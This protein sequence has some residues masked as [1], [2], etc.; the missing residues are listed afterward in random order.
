MKIIK[1]NSFYHNHLH[2]FLD[3]FYKDNLIHIFTPYYE[4]LL[5]YNITL[6]Y[7][8]EILKLKNEYTL[9]IYE[10]AK[11]KLY[12]ISSEESE[13]D[14]LVESEYGNKIFHLEHIK[15]VKDKL[16]ITSTMF[17]DDYN[18]FN[19]YYDYYMKHG[20]DYFYM[21]YN[22]IITPEIMKIF[23]KPNVQLIEWDFRYYIKSQHN[24]AIH[25]AQPSQINHAL[26]RFGKGFTQY[27]IFNDFDEYMSIPKNIENNHGIKSYKQYNLRDFV[28]DNPFDSYYFCNIW[29]NTLDNKIP[30]KFPYTFKIGAK[31]D[32]IGT[33][34]KCIHNV[35]TF[36]Y[37]NIHECCDKIETSKRIGRF[38]LFHFYNWSNKKRVEDTKDIIQV[39]L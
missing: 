5:N 20:V 30:S 19:V 16:L 29:S 15:S 37:V 2:I 8:G 7:N 23:D 13:V 22:G 1:T 21:Y 25:Y 9:P 26:Y 32:K 28:Q 33:R 12:D 18:L 39:I 11:V 31:L 17:K 38:D 24:I 27:M 10:S 4:G 3:I 34:T 36:N 35:D 6:K 14:V